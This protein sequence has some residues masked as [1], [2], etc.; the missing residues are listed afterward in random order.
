MYKRQN[1]RSFSP[2]LSSIKG[3][4]QDYLVTKDESLVPAAPIL[5]DY[6]FDWTGIDLFQVLQEKPG[7]LEFKI[8][9]SS[10]INPNRDNLKN[11]IIREFSKL[12]GYKF[13]IKVSFHNKIETTN[14]GK[15]RYVDQRLK[16]SMLENEL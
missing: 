11:R 15:F 7:I 2:I 4:V 14:R 3:R 5:F 9:T 12:F 6:N 10:Y 16:V 1:L 13:D 8:V